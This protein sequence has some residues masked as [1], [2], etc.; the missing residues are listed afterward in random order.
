MGV[1]RS[2]LATLVFGA[3]ATVAQV[4]QA[5]AD[6][7]D[8]VMK[9]HAAQD[10][11]ER[12][13]RW[14]ALHQEI[15]GARALSEGGDVIQIE[16]PEHALDAAL[17]PVTLTMKGA[18]PIKSVYLVIDNNPAPLA[19]HFSFGPRA[20]PRTL[21][22][23]V[24]VNMYTYMHAVAETTDGKLFVARQFIKTSGGCSAP[25]GADDAAAMKDIGLMKLHILGNFSPGK[26]LQAQ[27]MIRH[28]NFNGMQMDQVTRGF[29]PARFIRSIDASYDGAS[30]FHLD[31][32]I[33][34][35]TDPVI[36]FGFVPDRK[37][38]MQLVVRD[39][40]DVAFNHSFDVP[41]G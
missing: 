18:Q 12:A 3:I 36:T 10:E 16:A 39:S 34:L 32:D 14:Q 40:K 24:R 21:K 8:A 35:S 22:L 38:T 30:V 1:T 6:D 2:L 26:P 33:S 4:P 41:A 7:A 31:S 37:G 23:R 29:T 13:A 25:V 11:A 9:A 28:P 19:G 27:L 17:V 5:W 20:D 15:F